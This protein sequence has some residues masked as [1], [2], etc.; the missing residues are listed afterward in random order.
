MTDAFA[1]RADGRDERFRALVTELFRTI[2]RFRPD[3]SDT[4]LREAAE[5][6]AAYRLADEEL[7]RFDR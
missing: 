6:M 7:A 2:G 1:W 3:L 4:L 5:Q